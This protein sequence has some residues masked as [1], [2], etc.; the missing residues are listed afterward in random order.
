MRALP[1]VKTKGRVSPFDFAQGGQGR[2]DGKGG[3]GYYWT[4]KYGGCP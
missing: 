3:V 4:G 2:L 1:I